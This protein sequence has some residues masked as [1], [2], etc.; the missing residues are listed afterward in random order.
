MLLATEVNLISKKK[1]CKQNLIRFSDSNN[2]KV[3]FKLLTKVIILYVELIIID[4]RGPD[5]ELIP[6]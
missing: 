6:K 3:V 1:G 5:F 2:G 4:M